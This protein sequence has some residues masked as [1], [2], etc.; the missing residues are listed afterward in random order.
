MS[1][2][3]YVCVCVCVCVSLCVYNKDYSNRIIINYIPC[4]LITCHANYNYK[5]FI[6]CKQ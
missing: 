1:V 5:I 2:C 3:V 6:N 4:I